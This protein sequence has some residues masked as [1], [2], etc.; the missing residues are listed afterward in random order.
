M[1]RRVGRLAAR[2]HPRAATSPPPSLSL[3]S[4]VPTRAKRR[5][6]GESEVKLLRGARASSSSLPSRG[7]G[8]AGRRRSHPPRFVAPRRINAVMHFLFFPDFLGKVSRRTS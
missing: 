6:R 2:G 5:A 7:P 1:G 3:S 8:S 4:Q